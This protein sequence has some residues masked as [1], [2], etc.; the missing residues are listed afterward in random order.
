MEN[1][2]VSYSEVRFRLHSYNKKRLNFYE[3]ALKNLALSRNF[4]FSS[5][6]L[7]IV[8]KK[9]SVLRS[10]HVN[11]KAKEHYEYRLLSRLVI[12]KNVKISD[13]D[14]LENFNKFFNNEI[15]I[16]VSISYYYQR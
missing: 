16:K 3:V 7:P 8:S 15:A 6:K 10:P 4:A 14:F 1:F 5:I 11:K 12:L 13:F 9:F 2:V